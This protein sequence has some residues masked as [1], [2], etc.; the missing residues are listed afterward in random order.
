MKE[1]IRFTPRIL[2]STDG[3]NWGKEDINSNIIAT[4]PE[5]IRKHY[6]D[7]I[8]A[9]RWMVS[10]DK[11]KSSRAHTSQGETSFRNLLDNHGSEI[12]GDSHVR[13]F[14]PYSG[15]IMK[16]LDTHTD[17]QRGSLSIQIHP[18]PGH[19]SWPS[20][21]E[22]WMG[23]GS[24][25]FGWKEDMTEESI[26]KAIDEN[27]LESTM[28]L[29]QLRSEDLLL[30]PGGTIHAIRFNS[31]LKEWSKAPGTDEIS[32]GNIQDASVALSDSTDGK[33]PRPN[34]ANPQRTFDIMRHAE[35]FSAVNPQHYFSKPIIKPLPGGMERMLFNTA[36]VRVEEYISMAGAFSL[37]LEKRGLPLYVE[38]GTFEVLHE[39]KSL[40]IMRPGEEAF[41]PAS[42]QQVTIVPKPACH[43]YTWYRP[44]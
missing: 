7:C 33:T 6:R 32:K 30:V 23:K 42:L 8:V 17:P 39:G 16:L 4:L 26:M 18:M 1:L 40:G 11:D 28:N 27:R 5:N 15:T 13:L 3:Y 37:S 41:L 9:E 35:T 29:I 14:G 21:P 22:M 24:V 43:F 19:P 31:F 20:K 36:E 12:L 44:Y 2:T 38:R 10:D 34:K 25:Y